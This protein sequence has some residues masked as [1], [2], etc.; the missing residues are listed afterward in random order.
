MRKFKIF[1][2]KKILITGHNGF[3]GS[4]LSIW[5]SLLGAKVV[6][7]SLPEKSLDNHFNLVKNIDQFPEYR[8]YIQFLGKNFNK[9]R[10][11]IYENSPYSKYT[12]YS[13]NKGEEFVFCL[14]CKTTNNFHT[15]NLLTYVAVHEMAHAGCPEI[16]HTPLFNKI[17]KFFLN[18]GMSL[19]IY[20]YENYS[21][22]PVNYCGLR[23]YTNILN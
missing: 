20:E 10:T 16:G 3:K 13:V 8:E 6:G 22:N 18:E 4:W 9:N 1:K 7:I 14:K 17:F 21:N 2:N 11:L 19:K 23:L 15:L 12:S 5:L